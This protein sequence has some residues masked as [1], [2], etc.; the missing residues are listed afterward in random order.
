MALD[1]DEAAKDAYRKAYAILAE[2]A[3][4][5]VTSYFAP[6]RE[7]AQVILSQPIE[8]LHLD[9]Q[10][11]SKVELEAIL[12]SLPE[13]VKL[14]LGIVD[15]RNI[16]RNK[17]RQSLA[18]LQEI[19]A[20]IGSERL[21]ISCS[22]SLLHS[23][24]DLS[25]EKSQLSE[26]IYQQLAFSRQKLDELVAL[27]QG[28][29]QGEATIAP[30]LK[31]SDAAITARKNSQ[32]INDAAVQQ[33]LASISCDDT[34]RQSAFAERRKK[35]VGKLQ[36]PSS[37]LPLSVLSRRRH[38]CASSATPSARAKLLPNSTEHTWK[39]RPKSA[40]KSKKTWV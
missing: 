17:L 6:L 1:L 10:N 15:G 39:Q 14:S 3:K 28:L 7:N 18:L 19:A 40:S 13:G 2:Q 27:E 11:T 8:T 38:K 36:L 9:L 29:E 32:L 23:P 30:A 4:L 31:A 12:A 37:R 33:R 24:V 26:D 35:Q 5:F 16:W 20:K 22:C 25:W 21:I 34:E